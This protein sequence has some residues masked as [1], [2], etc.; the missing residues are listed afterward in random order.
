MIGHYV[1]HVGRA[2][3]LHGFLGRTMSE[4]LG[5]REAHP[6]FRAF[7]LSGS[8]EVYAYEERASRT[9]VICKFFGPRFGWDR[10]KAAGTAYREYEGLRTLRGY[11]LVG[12]PHHVIRPLG[13]DRDIN[14]VLALEYYPGELLGE[15]ISRAVHGHDSGHLFRR[16]TALAYYLATQ[17]NRTANGEG[18]DFDSDC[19]YLDSLVGRLRRRGRIGDWDVDELSWLRDHWQVRPRMW[20]DQ[21]VWL[22]GDAT[23]ANFLFGH[24]MDVA[25]IDLERMKRGDR[26]FD[27]GRVAGELQHAFLAAGDRHRAEQFIGHFLWEYSCHFPDREDAFRSITSRAPYYMAVNLLRI[28]RNDYISD[29][30]AGTLIDQAKELL[31]AC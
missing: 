3:P 15:A 12:S 24:G 7:R 23:P 20:Q 8:N 17:H 19:R 31:R 2:D 1:G 14:C 10:D 28:A 25:A 26:M 27:V 21:Q 11:D 6:H 22:H 18:V 4:R 13:M 5:V 30:Y 16:L 29:R 9:R